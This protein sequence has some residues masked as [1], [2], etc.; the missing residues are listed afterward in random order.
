VA[1]VNIAVIFGLDHLGS[2][3]AMLHITPLVILTAV[4]LNGIASLTFGY[5]YWTRGLEA[6]MLAHLSADLVFHVIGTALFKA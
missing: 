2:A 4:M 5:L 3:S 6:T 1:N